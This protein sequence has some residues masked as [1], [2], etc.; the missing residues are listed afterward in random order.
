M[1]SVFLVFANGQIF[2]FKIFSRPNGRDF[3]LYKVVLYVFY[4]FL[5][6]Q[7]KILSIFPHNLQQSIDFD[8]FGSIFLQNCQILR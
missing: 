7:A 3:L 4:S 5:A 1:L 6:P 2:T 8:V